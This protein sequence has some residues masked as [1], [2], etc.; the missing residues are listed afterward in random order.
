MI[1]QLENED[2]HMRFA[3]TEPFFY[4]WEWAQH[5]GLQGGSLLLCL[6]APKGE[7]DI[8]ARIERFNFE[9]EKACAGAT[10]LSVGEGSLKDTF[11][12]GSKCSLREQ[13]VHVLCRWGR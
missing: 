10:L 3:A 4:A 8:P 7:V 9:S 1:V 13:S 2:S 5:S 6:G 12:K 11:D